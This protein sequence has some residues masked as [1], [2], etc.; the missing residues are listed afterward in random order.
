M[1][2]LPVI[3][4]ARTVMTVPA[5]ELAPLL[6][7]YRQD[8][9]AHLAPWEPARMPAYYTE[10]AARRRLAQSVDEARTGS[11]LHF[12][13][14]EREGGAVVATCSFT[15]IVHG[16]FQACHV[17]FSVTASRQGSGLMHEVA[18]AGIDYMFREQKLHRI[19]ASHMPR[20]LRSAALLDR[21][22]FEREGYARAYL[23]I[24]GHWEDM[25]LSA[26]INPAG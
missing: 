21:L 20:N 6:L 1:H 26:L 17:G 2:E 8:N 24:D 4:T 12:I 18:R 3:E 13:A 10:E 5:P 16:V 22:G 25:V 23:R 11:A 14:C 15:N 9:R 7:A 19:M